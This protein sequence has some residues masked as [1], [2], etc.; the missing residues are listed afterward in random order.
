M[1]LFVVSRCGN[2]ATLC[3]QLHLML[4]HI[5]NQSIDRRKRVY[6]NTVTPSDFASE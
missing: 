3:V 5:I 6:F 1:Q 2:T 4:Y